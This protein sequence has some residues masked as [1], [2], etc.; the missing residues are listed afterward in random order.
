[1]KSTLSAKRKGDALITIRQN[2]NKHLVEICNM[3]NS[4]EKLTGYHLEEILGLGFNSILPDRINESLQDYIEFEDP[5]NDFAS[6]ARKIPN[7][8]IISKKGNEIAVSM[9]IFYLASENKGMQEYELLLRDIRLIKKIDELKSKISS[10]TDGREITDVNGLM[11]AYD[12]AYEF[13][14]DYPI[15]VTFATFGIDSYNNYVVHHDD[16]S[17]IEILNKFAKLIKQTCRTE[18]VVAYIDKG[19]IG[20]ILL[21]CNTENAR[22]VISRILDKA[23]SHQLK[24]IDGSNF[25]TT[26]SISYAQIDTEYSPAEIFNACI[27]STFNIQDSGG[28][29]IT[30]LS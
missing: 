28:N 14:D 10:E 15:E 25:N 5:N 13:V 16:I 12:T 22:D 26:L 17:L 23:A 30:E 19:V 3:N 6:V 20:V 29:A 4:A 27:D 21:D 24:M 7:F 9:K 2:N 18:D 8:Q 1:M 11:D